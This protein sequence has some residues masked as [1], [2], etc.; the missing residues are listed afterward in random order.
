M[1]LYGFYCERG[2][3]GGGAVR[4]WFGFFRWLVDSCEKE[5]EVF[6]VWLL[7]VV[8]GEGVGGKGSNIYNK[9]RNEFKYSFLLIFWYNCNMSLK[10]RSLV[11][12]I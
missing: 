7:V 12:F 11:V 1:V 8:L 3:V 2:F 6:F 4:V 10:I 9:I 5:C